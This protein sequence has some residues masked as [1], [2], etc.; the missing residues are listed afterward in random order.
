MPQGYQV[1]S[2]FVKTGDEEV[3]RAGKP[4]DSGAAQERKSGEGHHFA[5]EY[6]INFHPLMGKQ[7]KYKMITPRRES[8]VHISVEM[9]PSARW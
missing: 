8:H 5:P 4:K 1:F 9:V 3:A 7:K 6:L 2:G